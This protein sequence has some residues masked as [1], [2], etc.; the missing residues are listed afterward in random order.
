MDRSEAKFILTRFLEEK[1]NFH[2]LRRLQT[3]EGNQHA[4]VSWDNERI[5]ALEQDIKRLRAEIYDLPESF[6]VEC[7]VY[8]DE[9]IEED[10]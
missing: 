10:E 1:L 3:T 2:K 4:D 6:P 8:L 9:P 5:E 7:I